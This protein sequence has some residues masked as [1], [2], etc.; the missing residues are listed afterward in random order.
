MLGEIE[1]GERKV[2]E[3]C[4]TSLILFEKKLQREIKVGWTH[5]FYYSLHEVE[6]RQK[7]MPNF[8][9]CFKWIVIKVQRE[10]K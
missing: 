3:R 10:M 6:E 4:Q 8:Y 5:V 2:E 1:V 7:E 9:A